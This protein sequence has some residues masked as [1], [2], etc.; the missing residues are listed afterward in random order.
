MSGIGDGRERGHSHVSASR[1]EIG[2]C[3]ERMVRSARSLGSAERG[4][5]GYGEMFSSKVPRSE[6]RWAAVSSVS[7][8]EA[9]LGTHEH[10]ENMRTAGER[11]S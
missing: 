10:E 9:E 3:V 8:A 6:E 5:H 2:Q 4:R 7:G 1:R 11:V